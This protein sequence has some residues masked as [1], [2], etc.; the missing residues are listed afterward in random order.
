MSAFRDYLQSYGQQPDFRFEEQDESWFVFSLLLIRLGI[1]LPLIE[2]K[3]FPDLPRRVPDPTQS[4]LTWRRDSGSFEI[5]LNVPV[6]LC[7]QAAEI[8]K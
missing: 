8:Q 3:A 5:R 6:F 2:S 1:R 4:V 7:S